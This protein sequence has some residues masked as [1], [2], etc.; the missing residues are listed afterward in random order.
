MTKKLSL[1]ALWMS[2]VTLIACILIFVR[3]IYIVS[4]STNQNIT[5][6]EKQ[7]ILDL[8]SFVREIVIAT[9][10]SVNVVWY[11][12]LFEPFHDV[13]IRTW[14]RLATGRMCVPPDQAFGQGP[15]AHADQPDESVHADQPDKYYLA[16]QPDHV[17]SSHSVLNMLLLNLY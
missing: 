16:E 1:V 9:N 3:N 14:R 15:L 4:T 17:V 12:V 7:N 13:I 10:M 6:P 8:F 2:S 11:C 5:F